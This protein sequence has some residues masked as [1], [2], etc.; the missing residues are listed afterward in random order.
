MKTISLLH[1][2]TVKLKT[3]MIVKIA[4]LPIMC[5]YKTTAIQSNLEISPYPQMAHCCPKINSIN[6]ENECS[7][8]NLC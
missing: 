4:I 8:S 2:Q 6:K 5:E 3:V 7:V 1:A